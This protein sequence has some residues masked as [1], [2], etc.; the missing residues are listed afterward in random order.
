[1]FSLSDT[2]ELP[3]YAIIFSSQRS[4]DDRSA[5]GVMASQMFDLAAE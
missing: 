5:Y 3:H 1:M 2:L 4:E